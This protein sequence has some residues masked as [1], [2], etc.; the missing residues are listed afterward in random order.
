MESGGKPVLTNVFHAPIEGFSALAEGPPKKLSVLTRKL[1][2]L[3]LGGLDLGGLARME[4]NV[5]TLGA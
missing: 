3:D 4:E 5:G 1:G 2:R